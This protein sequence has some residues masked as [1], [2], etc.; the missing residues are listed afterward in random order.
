MD[1][2]SVCVD[3]F[4]VKKR[5]PRIAGARI[6]LL[7]SCRVGVDD[8]FLLLLTPACIL[9]FLKVRQF[10]GE[11]SDMPNSGPSGKHV[12]AERLFH[13]AIDQDQRFLPE[14]FG[15]LKR[16]LMCLERFSDFVRQHIVQENRKTA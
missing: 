11:F 10:S 1:G 14:E 15:H 7:K 5:R 4:G 12:E 3:Y 8:A 6:W 13:I 16:C 2:S 9:G